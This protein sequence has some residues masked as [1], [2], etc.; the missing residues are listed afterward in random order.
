M[1]ISNLQTGDVAKR[2]GISLRAVR[3]YEEEGLLKPSAMTPGGL[4]L[5]DDR[6]VFR[7]RFINTLR[8]LDIS[9]QEIKVVLGV[10]APKPGTK[11]EVLERSLKALKIT[12]SKINEQQKVLAD[13]LETN[14]TALKSVEA[15][16]RCDASSC[17]ACPQQ[18]YFLS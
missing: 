4:R 3:Y 5:Y 14:N 15:C 18:M 11:S 7:L 1:N 8:R 13:L 6:D 16:Q 2:V 12:Q 17:G 10:D 9:I